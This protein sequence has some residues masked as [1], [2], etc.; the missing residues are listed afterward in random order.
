MVYFFEK[1]RLLSGAYSGMISLICKYHS[2]FYKKEG[3]KLD[4]FE[5]TQFEIAGQEF[6]CPVTNRLIDKVFRGYSLILYYLDFLVIQQFSLSFHLSYERWYC[7][8]IPQLFD[9]YFL[10]FYFINTSKCI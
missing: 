4:F 3:Y 5:K 6:L 10:V 9:F 8:A 7:K 2:K 1:I